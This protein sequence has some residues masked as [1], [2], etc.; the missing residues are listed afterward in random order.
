MK[1][2]YSYLNCNQQRYMINLNLFTFKKNQK[3]SV[4]ILIRGTLFYIMKTMHTY[5]T[6]RSHGEW[7][8]T[9]PH[10]QA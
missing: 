7:H 5:E 10:G 8:P 2:S 6:S 9:P 3:V 1:K 4:G